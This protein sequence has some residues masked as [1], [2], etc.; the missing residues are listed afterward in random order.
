MKPTPAELGP[1]ERGRAQA[2]L[3][4]ALRHGH[5]EVELRSQGGEADLFVVGVVS[6]WMG[7]E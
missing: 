3:D 1:E 6:R 4:G 5:R 7:G 2:I